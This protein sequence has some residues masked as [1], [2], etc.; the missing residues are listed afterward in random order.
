VPDVLTA[1]ASPIEFPA[2]LDEWVSEQWQSFSLRRSPRTPW[3]PKTV[4]AR[5]R[6][7][8]T[9]LNAYYPTVTDVRL[10]AMRRRVLRALAAWRYHAR[11][12]WRPLELNAVQRVF[13]YQRPETT[14]F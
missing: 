6:N 1:A 10:T 7:F 4:R 2:S 8:E 14:G 11:I 13:R 12:E 9:V 5:V 3:A